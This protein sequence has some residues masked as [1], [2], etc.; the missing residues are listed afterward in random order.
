MNTK[1]VTAGRWLGVLPAAVLAFVLV[2]LLLDF[3]METFIRDILKVCVWDPDRGCIQS[4]EAGDGL[5]QLWRATAIS[6]FAPYAAIRA[7]AAMAPHYRE[8]VGLILGALYLV[9]LGA[10]LYG[11]ILS[12]GRSVGYPLWAVFVSAAFLLL[13]CVFAVAQELRFAFFRALLART[14]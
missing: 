2:T 6:F 10:G 3:T 14:R 12:G 9:G 11:A 4:P 13:G 7:G 5:R 1:L 8:V